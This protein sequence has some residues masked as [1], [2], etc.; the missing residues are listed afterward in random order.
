MDITALLV[1]KSILN[2]Y[3]IVLHKIIPIVSKMMELFATLQ[4]VNFGVILKTAQIIVL[5]KMDNLVTILLLD[6][7]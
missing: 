6:C 3:L 1:T 2:Q 4:E 7:I 5:L